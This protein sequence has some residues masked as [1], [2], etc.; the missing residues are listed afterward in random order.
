MNMGIPTEDSH[1]H[2]SDPR[3][4]GN[5]SKGKNYSNCFLN[6]KFFALHHDKYRKTQI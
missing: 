5:V 6:T 2:D 4:M 1:V 3:H